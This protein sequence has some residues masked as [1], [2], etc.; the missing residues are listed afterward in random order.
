MISSAVAIPDEP[1][2]QAESPDQT[3]SRKRRQSS[4]SSESSKRPRLD[5]P[6]SNGAAN[7]RSSASRT[8]SPPTTR[9]GADAM[10]PP[11]QPDSGRRKSSLNVEQDKSRNR[12]LFG[13]L[14]GTLSQSARP[15][16]S[17]AGSNAAASGRNSRREEIENRQRERLKK[18][19]EELADS[20]RRKKEEL[21]RVRRGEQ[22]R[23]EDEGMNLRH[24][25]LRA[26]AR[27]LKTKA[28]PPLY[29]KPWEVREQDEEIIKRQVDE[30][31]ETIR[32][33]V[34]ESEVKRRPAPKS[35]ESGRHDRD[36]DVED[37]RTRQTD[38]GVN[39]TS[40]EERPPVS[41]GNEP[42]P[43]EREDESKTVQTGVSSDVETVPEQKVKDETQRPVS[44]DDDHGGE[45]LELGQEDDVIY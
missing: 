26:T 16:K 41:S 3:T 20:A 37:D 15:S 33:E 4:V 8:H 22:R 19:N 39:G 9:N 10:S 27:F 44:K 31:E 34:A 29:Y 25:N 32:R 14:L 2:S 21:D 45:E 7:L 23:W 17:T 36:T 5:A 43:S 35:P 6:A 1:Q 11:G 28:E 40:K 12:R 18:E 30:A 24:R 13:S 38:Y 42:E